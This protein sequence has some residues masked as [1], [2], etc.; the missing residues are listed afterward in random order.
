VT[1]DEDTWAARERRRS[2]IWSKVDGYPAGSH[3]MRPRTTS[4][5]SSAGESSGSGTRYKVGSILSL[6]HGDEEVI[7]DDD[8]VHRRSCKD[9]GKK[10]R[11]RKG[12]ILSLFRM[13]KDERGRNVIHSGDEPPRV[14]V[15]VT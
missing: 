5:S 6:F 1:H 14:E 12:S 13:G 7:K 8:G 10:V 4:G 11:E 3:M 15:D 9:M 2:S